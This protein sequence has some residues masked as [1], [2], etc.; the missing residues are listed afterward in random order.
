MPNHPFNPASSLRINGKAGIV[1]KTKSVQQQSSVFIKR[2]CIAPHITRR[3]GEW[4]RGE[5]KPARD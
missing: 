2:N 5:L 1:G 4:R 3:L